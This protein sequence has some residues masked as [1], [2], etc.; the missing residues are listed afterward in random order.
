MQTYYNSTLPAA[1]EWTRS[2]PGTRFH[3]EM[4]GP[5]AILAKAFMFMVVAALLWLVATHVATV[6]LTLIAD[7]EV[8]RTVVS[9]DD[10]IY[11]EEIDRAKKRAMPIFGLSVATGLIALTLV[12]K[13]IRVYRG[14][15]S[16][17]RRV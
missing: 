9:D 7:G 6:R 14:S 16:S 12:R 4:P 13:G 8:G 1:V 2:G 17:L 5:T 15:R 10:P 3:S 11:R